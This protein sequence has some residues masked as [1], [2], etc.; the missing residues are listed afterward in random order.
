MIALVLGLAALALCILGPLLAH[1]QL[2]PAMA[3]FGIFILSGAVGLVAVVVAAYL[4]V[5]SRGLPIAAAGF[6]GILP[7]A[8]IVVGAVQGSGYPAINDITTDVYDVPKFNA[9]KTFPGNVG[10]QLSFPERFA[11]I[12]E[13]SY[14][15]LEPLRTK[16]PPDEAFAAVR[17]LA[18]AQGWEHLTADGGNHRLEATA[19]SRVFRF[20]DDVVIRVEAAEDGGSRIDMRSKSRDGRSD[21]GV[22]AARIKQFLGQLQQRLEPA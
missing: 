22:N 13:T 1:F 10:R 21:F 7:L 14:P 15:S 16:Q 18:E 6:L 19:A 9:A 20:K 8:A 11:P 12:I 2:A 5:A 17:E 4:L 3:G